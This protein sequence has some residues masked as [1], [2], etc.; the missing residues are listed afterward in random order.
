MLMGAR[1]R[2]IPARFPRYFPSFQVKLSVR[3]RREGAFGRIIIIERSE[4]RA[5]NV[6]IDEAPAA[7]LVTRLVAHRPPIADV[8]LALQE[9]GLM[10][11]LEPAQRLAG[12]ANNFNGFGTRHECAGDPV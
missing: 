9:T 8:D 6:R 10:A 11:A 12:K 5:E 7:A 4:H 1:R 2:S 3:A